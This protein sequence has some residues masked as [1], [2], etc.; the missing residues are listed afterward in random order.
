MLYF[1]YGSNLNKFQMERRCPDSIPIA[2]VRLRNYKL[3]FNRV[4]DI[5]ESNGDIVEGAI[6][7]VSARDIRNLNVYE[8]YPRLYTKVDVIVE[9]DSGKIYKAFAYVMV[10]KGITPPNKHY[11]GIIAEGYRDWNLPTLTLNKARRIRA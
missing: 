8:G 10:E 3:V 7:D 1:A 11:F 4:A 5:I 6:Y 9:D 2:K